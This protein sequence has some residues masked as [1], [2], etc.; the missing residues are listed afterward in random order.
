MFC[1]TPPIGPFAI[2]LITF[3]TT[4]AAGLNAQT[5]WE[6]MP[7][8]FSAEIVDSQRGGRIATGDLDGDGYRDIVIHTW[9]SQ[10]GM[11]ADGELIWYRYPDWTPSTIASGKH[12]FGDV[13]LAADLD[14]D[15]DLD[16][17]APKGNGG[18]ADIWWYE[19][20]GDGAS[21]TEH[22]LGLSGRG[23]EIKDLEAHDMDGDGRVDIVSRIT[24]LVVIW[25]GNQDGSWTSH[26][27][28]IVHREGMKLADLDA[29]GDADILLNGYWLENPGSRADNW[30]RFDFDPRWFARG[31]QPAMD[32]R[33]RDYAVRLQF[34]P[35]V[36]G[37]PPVIIASHAEHAGFPV[38]WYQ[39]ENPRGGPEAWTAHEIGIVD[40]AHTLKAADFDNNG[41]I[42]ILAAGSLH[43]A[44]S[45]YTFFFNNGNGE[46]SR[47][48]LAE[49]GPTYAA[50]VADI[51]NDGDPDII[52]PRSWTDA[53][54]T[55]WR[56]HS[57]RH[58]TRT[59]WRRQ[60]VDGPLNQQLIFVE[61]HDIDG[62]GALDIIAG[63]R[64]YHQ[65]APWTWEPRQLPEPFINFATAFDV[66]QDGDIDL[67]G[68]RDRPSNAFVWLENDGSGG[69]TVHEN[70]QASEGDFLQ[71]V[72]PLTDAS[73]QR[74]VVLSWHARN[75]LT[76]AY[77]VPQ[78]PSSQ[79]WPLVTLS[80]NS[81]NEDL[82]AGDID[83][84]G[85]T[86]LLLGTIWLEQTPSGWITH[87]IGDFRWLD[88]DAM[89]DRNDLA[90]IDGDGDLDAV[91]AQELGPYVLWYENP[92]RPGTAWR[93]HV[94]D[95][96]AGQ[97]FSMDTF[98]ADGDGDPDVVVGEHRNPTRVNRIVLLENRQGGKSWQTHLL[99]DGAGV[100]IDHHDGTQRADLDGDGDLDLVSIGWHNRSVWVYE[101]KGLDLPQPAFQ[102]VS[103]YAGL[104]LEVDP[105]ATARLP[106]HPVEVVLDSRQL[107]LIVPE[108]DTLS[109]EQL[110][111]DERDASGRVINANLPFQLSGGT[112]LDPLAPNLTRLVFALPGPTAAQAIRH[113]RI[114]PR[115]AGSPPAALIHI[116]PNLFD[117][118]QAA[119]EVH[120]PAS[121]LRYHRY[122]AG[123]SS[124]IDADGN[125]WI[126]YK[127]GDGPRGEFRGIP[128]M[129][130]PDG[131]MHPG[132]T[133]SDTRIL[134]AGPVKVTLASESNDG[135]WSGQWE[136]YP[137]FAKMT[138]IR[139]HRPFW[140]LYEGTPGGAIDRDSDFWIR[141]DGSTGPIHE[142]WQDHRMNADWVAFADPKLGRSILLSHER[143][144]SE[145]NSYWLMEDAMT[146]FGFGRRGLEKYIDRLP[147]RFTISLHDNTTHPH[148]A[149]AVT[150]FEAP[151]QTSIRWIN[152]DSDSQ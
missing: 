131:Y 20:G 132:F 62:D 69:W 39:T 121:T 65:T 73:G 25:Y 11:E 93:R 102:S 108:L 24:D 40:Y 118:G 47:W 80:E 35:L 31:T 15:G 37:E 150:A 110:Q 85:D 135:L 27:T 145:L 16:V 92:G 33:W 76:Q 113:F 10:R 14:H 119:I 86:D 137:T 112:A 29:D 26:S 50:I 84:D 103:R 18:V 127:P 125:D 82:S 126:S 98:D 141:A 146:V 12:F 151:V 43:K 95:L 107:S 66:D 87:N 74:W 19:N 114:I 91:V 28:A 123:F 6:S 140:F 147:R 89:P 124:W 88:D 54:L 128:N 116:T 97:G 136:I 109:P 148:L 79:T 68:T 133:R 1:P 8:A 90:D 78:S 57:V 34:A 45:R 122:G 99:D 94:I 4:G 5:V 83:G 130:H 100:A 36:R 38:V 49:S 9:G 3:A 152:D 42:D 144:Q 32:A 30:Q 64:W 2:T 46:F 101:N 134:E 77:Q 129:G 21:W 52:G 44:E 60:Q 67:L 143:N 117:A 106:L 139:T 105:G 96:V 63:S 120:L 104:H 115:T 111:L 17:V 53:P 71:G 61:T 138:V 13:I 81:Q 149:A 7:A 58:Q 56:N 72:L 75:P 59:G 51:D 22:H 48:E 23:S 70:L 142:G 41:T 55:L